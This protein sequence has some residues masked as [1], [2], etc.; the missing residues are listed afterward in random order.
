M[1]RKTYRL[2]YS[3]LR[4]MLVAVGETA[5]ATGKAAGQTTVPKRSDAAG[6]TAGHTAQ[7]TLRQIA[8]AALALLG[9]LPAFSGAITG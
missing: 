9:V 2:V 3:R 7:F 4:G 6:Y 1:N 5:T 8:F